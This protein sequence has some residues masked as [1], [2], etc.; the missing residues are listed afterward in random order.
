MVKHKRSREMGDLHARGFVSCI[1]DCA[2]A[3]IIQPQNRTEYCSLKI[4]IKGPHERP[5]TSAAQT[6][7]NRLLRILWWRMASRITLHTL[8]YVWR[9]A[10][11]SKTPVAR[12]TDK[13]KLKAPSIAPHHCTH[14][15]HVCYIFHGTNRTQIMIQPNWKKM[16]MVMVVGKIWKP[17][18]LWASY[19]HTH[20]RNTPKQKHPHCVCPVAVVLCRNHLSRGLCVSWQKACLNNAAREVCLQ[21]TI[22]GSRC[23]V[24]VFSFWWIFAQVQLYGV[25]RGI[26]TQTRP[27]PISLGCFLLLLITDF[28]CW[29]SSSSSS[30]SYAYQKNTNSHDTEQ[31]WEWFY[32]R[33]YAVLV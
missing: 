2:W 31:F 4:I 32:V 22:C 33:F 3:D 19:T 7:A 13:G 12:A 30:Y 11:S 1:V 5:L 10:F 15:S 9:F 6:Q 21:M 20:T 24:W 27:A 16:T 14:Q 8:T 26:E 28:C 25:Y 18:T 29:P 17:Q 23:Y